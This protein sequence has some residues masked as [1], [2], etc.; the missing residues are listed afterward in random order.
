MKRFLPT[1]ALFLCSC[2]LKAVPA[3]TVKVLFIGNSFT[4]NNNLPLLFQEMAIGANKAVVVNAYTPGG[5]SVG[6][7]SQGTSAHMNNPI[8]YN[9]IRSNN[10]DFLLL[11]DNQGRFVNTFGVFPS[12][13]LVI[14]GHIKIRDSL[15]YYHPCAKM[16]WFAGWGPKA[17]YLPYASTGTG[18]IDNIYNNYRYLLDTAQ[19]IIAPIGPAWQ[20]IIAND[21]SINLWDVD[22]VH[23]GLNGSWLTAAVVYS[24]VFKSSPMMS[25]YIP[26]G[27]TSA[28]DSILKTTGFNTV[29]DSI[30]VTGLQNITPQIVVTGNTLTVT[31]YPSVD[32]YLNDNFVATNAGVLN[33]S[34][35]GTY[36][37]I[38][39]NQN[40]CRMWTSPST[41]TQINGIAQASLSITTTLFPNPSQGSI[42]VESSERMIKIEVINYLGQCL[43]TILHPE[44]KTELDGSQLAKGVYWVRISHPDNRVEVLKMTVN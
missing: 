33:I 13:S 29:S 27:I 16:L 12:S 5:M 18:L 11:Q 4:S 19:Q 9:L 42:T 1:I 41:L 30:Q 21:T 31:G 3:D 39:H 17:G 25:T 8:V 14:Q 35:T 7:I 37:A 28:V 26:A 34:Q 6:D 40:N 23:P 22:D 15:L 36:T 10:W 20:R 32:W 38:V 2:I 43:Q 44:M 24:T